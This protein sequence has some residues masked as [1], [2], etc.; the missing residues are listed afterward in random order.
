M[1]LQIT[2]ESYAYSIYGVEAFGYLCRGTDCTV[3]TKSFPNGLKI[4]NRKG[5]FLM[6]RG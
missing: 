1:S 5:K 2:E 4:L 3:Y 6:F